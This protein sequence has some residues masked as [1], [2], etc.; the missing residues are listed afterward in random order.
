MF[1][2][3]PVIK[4]EIRPGFSS[5]SSC[6][7]VPLDDEGNYNLWISTRAVKKAVTV[8]ADKMSGVISGIMG[9][10][11]PVSCREARG[12]DATQYTLTILDRDSLSY[13]WENNLPEEWSAL[14]PV[15]AAIEAFSG[16]DQAD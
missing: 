9:L 12:F 1:S 14:R 4:Y 16:F 8:P 10:S 15:V 5:R 2:F 6:E 7:F 3:R 11:L 13:S